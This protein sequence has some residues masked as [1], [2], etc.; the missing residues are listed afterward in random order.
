MS[1]LKVAALAAA[2]LGIAVTH[3]A[4]KDAEARKRRK[5]PPRRV[6]K[7]AGEL[8]VTAPD[9]MCIT[10][11]ARA[12]DGPRLTIDE[13]TVRVVA[14]AS[15]GDAA[16]LRFTFNGDSE[17]K[18]ALASGQMRRQL[19]LKLR[20]GDGCNLVYVMWR[21][22]PT[23]F[24]EV[25]TKINPGSHDHDDCGAG[26]YTKVKA[27]R[28]EAPPPLRTGTTHTLSAEII[29]DELTARID[30]KVVWRG[31]LADDARA[32]DGPAGLRT[33]NVAIDAELLVAPIAKRHAVPG[34]D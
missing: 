4:C 10:R 23:P 20:A 28:S 8:Q 34:C 12:F 6:V 18:V 15:H 21:L 13:P 16:A 11:G 33:D 31:R 14:P 30:D 25:Q 19:G 17:K 22:D 24:V 9:A 27:V 3:V 1:R 32:L 26:G 2:C 5:S 7:P 29:G